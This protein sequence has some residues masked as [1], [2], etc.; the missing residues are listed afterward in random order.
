MKAIA[1]AQPIGAPAQPSPR[2][3]RPRL[4]LNGQSH[5]G[6]HLCRTHAL[7]RGKPQRGGIVRPCGQPRRAL[8]LCRPAG[9]GRHGGGKFYS[10]V[11]LDG[12]RP[13][14]RA[15]SPMNRWAILFRPA[16]LGSVGM[17]LRGRAA[18]AAGRKRG[19]KLIQIAKWFSASASRFISRYGRYHSDCQ[20]F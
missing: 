11:V 20:Y 8:N 12:T 18:G 3:P 5:Q 16:G 7:Q 9:A 17:A 1:K 13:V 15:L 10:D 19:A 2:L 4:L 6:R 14:Q